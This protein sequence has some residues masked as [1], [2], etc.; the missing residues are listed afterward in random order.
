MNFSQLKQSLIYTGLLYLR[1]SIYPQKEKNVKIAISAFAP[2]AA[3]QELTPN[4]K[5]WP[6][7]CLQFQTDVRGWRKANRYFFECLT[8]IGVRRLGHPRLFRAQ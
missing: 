3:I 5:D 7:I 6:E 4:G 8:R 1:N 2:I